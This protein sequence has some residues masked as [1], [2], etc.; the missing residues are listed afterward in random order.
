MDAV[1]ART[2]APD[3][4]AALDRRLPD[5]H[6][7]HAAPLAPAGPGARHA[8]GSADHP[9]APE[10]R[11]QLRHRAAIPGRPVARPARLPRRAGRLHRPRSARLRAR[12]GGL[13]QHRPARPGARPVRTGTRLAKRWRWPP[14]RPPW[15]PTRPTR[16][17]RSRPCA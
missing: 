16:K 14:K 2:G 7:R 5:A 15:A 6:R 10:E 1:R 11:A 9:R 12:P 17:T 3:R 4:L 8:Q 13:S